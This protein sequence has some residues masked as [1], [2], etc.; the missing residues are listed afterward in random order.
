M[1]LAHRWS[2]RNLTRTELVMA[3]LILSLMIGYFGHHM[4]TVFGKVE[5]SMMDRTLI[6]INSALN[7]QSA[8]A[9]LKKDQIFFDK[10]MHMNPMDLMT[11]PLFMDDL[12]LKKHNNETLISNVVIVP[13]NYGGAVI[14]DREPSLES[15]L[16]YFD[17]DDGLLFYKVNN[18]EFFTSDIGDPARVRFKVRVDYIDHNNDNSFDPSVDKFSSIKL[19]AIDHFEWSF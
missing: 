13:S 16:W 6:N 9:L 5:K 8:F 4:Y 7:V 3:L 14:D 10:I 2:D 15:G 12:L 19:E 1:E 17:Q 18:S 11:S